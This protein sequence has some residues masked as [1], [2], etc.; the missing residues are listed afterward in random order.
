MIIDSSEYH[1][2]VSLE[3]KKKLFV[4][5]ARIPLLLFVNL[6]REVV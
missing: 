1:G 4:L 6:I 5:L 2:T 3:K